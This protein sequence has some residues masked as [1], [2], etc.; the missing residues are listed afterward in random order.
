VGLDL[1][2]VPLREVQDPEKLQRFVKF[3]EVFKNLA[4]FVKNLGTFV[5]KLQDSLCFARIR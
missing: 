5:K 4:K 3:V 1:T 2:S